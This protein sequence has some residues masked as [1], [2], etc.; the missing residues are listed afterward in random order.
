[1]D[2]FHVHVLLCIVWSNNERQ[3]SAVCLCYHKVSLD[4]MITCLVFNGSYAMSFI[5]IAVLISMTF[6]SLF[7]SIFEEKAF[8]V[9]FSTLGA[10][11]ICIFLFQLFLL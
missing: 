4:T 7:N 1:M 8:H 2:V 9:M 11:L 3:I 10:V 5:D 6:P